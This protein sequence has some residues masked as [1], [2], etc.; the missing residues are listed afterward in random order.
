MGTGL[1]L[2]GGIAHQSNIYGFSCDNVASFEIV[3]ASGIILKVSPAA[4]PD[5]YWA[6]RGGGNNFGIVTKFNLETIPQGP[7]W[8]GVRVHLEPDYPA[9]MDAFASVV[10]GAKEDPK[11]AQILSFAVTAGR[12]AAQLQLEYLEPV[13]TANPPA[14]LKKYLSLAALRDTT[15]NRT[16]A[17][18]TQL[19]TGQMPSGHRYSFWAGTFKL[20]R[21]L[22][23]WMQTKHNKEV[24]PLPDQGSLTFQGFSVPTL[25]MTTKKGGNALGLNAADGPLMHVLLYMVWED[26]AKDAELNKAAQDFMNAAKAESERRG[27]ASNFI[28]LNYA[29]PYQNV[30]P[31]Y[32]SANLQKLKSIAKK[33]DPTA[34]F[35]T[36]QPGGFKL[37]G[38]PYGTL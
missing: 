15:V 32:G 35:Q 13:D 38:A 19:L 28:Y 24:G 23:A 36:L 14:S 5:L 18:D 22:M 20:D 4:F 7:M 33:Y 11:V 27:L 29:G 21:D 3:T 12:A 1:V 6:L 34:V 16:L 31:S 26:A 25:E 9:L 30:I 37:E 8:G 10:E 2:G 17:D